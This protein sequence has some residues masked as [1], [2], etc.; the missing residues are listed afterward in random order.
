MSL[1]LWLE[2]DGKSR[3]RDF[4]LNGGSDKLKYIHLY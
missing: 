2:E 3:Y 1:C 4:D